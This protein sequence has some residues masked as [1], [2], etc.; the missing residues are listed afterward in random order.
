MTAN[1][2][3][4]AIER[5]WPADSFLSQATRFVTIA[6]FGSLL[7]ALSSKIQVPFYP[8]PM[9][10]QTAVIFLLGLTL[11]PRLALATVGLYLLEG[12]FGLPIFAGTPVKGIGLAYMTG[13]TGG[14][15]LG[16]LL[17]ALVC[18]IAAR[19]AYRG[20]ALA[21][22]VLVATIAIYVPGLAWLSTFAG[23]ENA[24]TFGLLPF[25]LGDLVKL[26]LV[27]VLVETG[28][29]RGTGRA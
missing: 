3:S 10:M 18:G 13:P 7:L 8:V 1:S 29:H 27:V 28:V 12:A 16:F 11:G 14:Y 17:A 4:T 21:L 24:V 26:A 25:V 9:T 20:A 5:V 22:A 23:V 2:S 15:L 6:F 19:R